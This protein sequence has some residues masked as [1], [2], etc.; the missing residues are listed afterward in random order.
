V[1]RLVQ[2]SPTPDILTRL[3][4]IGASVSIGNTADDVWTDLS[5]P[6]PP[7]AV[8]RSRPGTSEY[9]AA[10]GQRWLGAIAELRGTPWA[11][12]VAFPEYF[13]FAPAYTFL[14]RMVL[15]AFVFLA[16]TA[17]A[18]RALSARIIRP[19]NDLIHAS[20]AVAGG[21]YSRRVATTRQDEIGTLGL[22]FNAMTE[23][24]E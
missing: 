15:L 14:Q 24:I 2:V 10:D 1:H 4:G 3:V 12:W 17:F 20:E 16:A 8:D 19:L 11:I 5:K 22:A 21:E 9:V 18:A 13:V 6:V 23:Q 7:P